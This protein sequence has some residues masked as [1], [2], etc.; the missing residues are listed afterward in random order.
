M[1]LPAELKPSA[2]TT[3]AP[4]KKNNR[5]AVTTHKKNTRVKKHTESEKN[6]ESTIH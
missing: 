2:V 3:C 1:I 5:I 6:I 4:P